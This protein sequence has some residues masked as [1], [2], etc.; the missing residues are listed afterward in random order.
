MQVAC[1]TDTGFYEAFSRSRTR[2]VIESIF[3]K[4]QKCAGNLNATTWITWIR[5]S[6]RI[7]LLL[8][9]LLAFRVDSEHKG[10]YES[11]YYYKLH[12]S[13]ELTGISGHTRN[14]GVQFARCNCKCCQ[15]RW[16]R[17]ETRVW[18]ITCPRDIGT[19]VQQVLRVLADTATVISVLRK[20]RKRVTDL[21]LTLFS[22]SPLRKLSRDYD[23]RRWSTHTH[24][25]CICT[26]YPKNI[27]WQVLE[28]ELTLLFQSYNAI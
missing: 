27:E 22:D 25:I 7:F 14:L 16:A 3:R 24:H 12:S 4:E 17:E 26:E 1:L 23:K 28:N 6:I 8:Y 15:S 21:Y 20:S 11:L 9:K 19:C 5:R 18:R 10:Q 13:F 2:H